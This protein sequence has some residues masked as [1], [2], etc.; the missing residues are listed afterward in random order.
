MKYAMHGN[1]GLVVSKLCF[2]T[3]TLG[4]GRGEHIVIPPTTLLRPMR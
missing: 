1:T 4:D 2:G 3:M